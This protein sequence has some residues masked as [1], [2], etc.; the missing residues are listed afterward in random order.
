MMTLYTVMAAI[1][2]VCVTGLV[3]IVVSA[4]KKG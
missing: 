3:V 2:M 4:S 1:A